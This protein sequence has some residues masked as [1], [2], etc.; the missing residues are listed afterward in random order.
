M[1][2]NGSGTDQN[3]VNKFA[4]DSGVVKVFFNGRGGGVSVKEIALCGKN[5]STFFL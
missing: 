2:D 3:L 5:M 4:I 1:A